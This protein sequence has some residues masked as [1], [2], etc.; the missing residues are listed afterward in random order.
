MNSR[1]H[2]QAKELGRMAGR[3]GAKPES[4]PFR[5]ASLHDK[6]D[7]W[8]AGRIEGAAERKVRKA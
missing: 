4:C 1:E 6:R 3:N 5:G 2:E 7:A 8:E